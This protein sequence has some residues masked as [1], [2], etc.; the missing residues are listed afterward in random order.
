MVE[1]LAHA[2]GVGKGKEN[3][4]A[5]VVVYSRGKVETPSPVFCP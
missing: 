2:V 5:V 4:V 3:V 1:G